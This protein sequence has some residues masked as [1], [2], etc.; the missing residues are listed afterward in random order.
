M[1]NVKSGARAVR[2]PVA[3][4]RR[5]ARMRSFFRPKRSLRA[6]ETREPRRQPTRALLMAQP[7]WDGVVRLK[8]FS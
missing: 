4:K 7:I 1:K 3:V 2:M 8:N 5:A 6:P